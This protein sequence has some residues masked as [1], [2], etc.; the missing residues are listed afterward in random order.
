MLEGCTRIECPPPPPPP[1]PPLLLAPPSR[2]SMPPPW[3]YRVCRGDRGDVQQL[4]GPLR[5]HDDLE[6]RLMVFDALCNGGRSLSPWLHW[7]LSRAVA[8]EYLKEAR[9]N[10]GD[11]RSY[12]IRVALPD[13]ATAR[14][15][16]PGEYVRLYSEH[17]AQAFFEGFMENRFVQEL[18]F[19]QR[20]AG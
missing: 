15:L 16:A 10:Y 12:M 17:E 5:V 9:L 1:P 7:T 20:R 8:N 18:V 3:A 11:E 19:S 6:L 13:H 14:H 4:A 2:R